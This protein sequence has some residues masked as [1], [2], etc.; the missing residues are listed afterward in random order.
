MKE[1]ISVLAYAVHGCV[2]LK[3]YGQLELML[4]VLPLMQADFKLPKER[5]HFKQESTR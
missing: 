3:Y 5:I 2:V 4:A 1:R